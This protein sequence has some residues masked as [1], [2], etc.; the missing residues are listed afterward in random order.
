[1]HRFVVPPVGHL[2]GR[3]LALFTPA[4]HPAWREKPGARKPPRSRLSATCRA[5][6]QHAL[7]L[8]GFPDPASVPLHKIKYFR[9]AEYSGFSPSIPSTRKCGFML[10]TPVPRLIKRP[11][12]RLGGATRDGWQKQGMCCQPGLKGRITL[13]SSRSAGAASIPGDRPVAWGCISSGSNHADFGG[14]LCRPN[15]DNP[16]CSFSD[17]AQ[18]LSRRQFS[19]AALLPSDN[20]DRFPPLGAPCPIFLPSRANAA[21][22]AR[23]I[24]SPRGDGNGTQ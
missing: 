14:R 4:V 13:T 16:H 12:R 1:M 18:A 24:F 17:T 6:K 11:A 7:H 9:Y 10:G 5:K 15:H 3:P 19:D 8:Y 2:H 20:K 21:R 22:R 23:I